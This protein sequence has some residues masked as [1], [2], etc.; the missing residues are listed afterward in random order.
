M[1]TTNDCVAYII[2]FM[3]LITSNHQE[4]GK[5]FMHGFMNDNVY[6]PSTCEQK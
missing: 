3:V 4:V 5:E 2:F 1:V 6:V